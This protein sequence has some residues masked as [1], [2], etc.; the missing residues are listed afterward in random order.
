MKR[1][2]LVPKSGSV[3]AKLFT[4][5]VSRKG[6]KVKKGR[7]KAM[8]AERV[9]TE[10][11]NA[12]ASEPFRLLT[13]LEVLPSDFFRVSTGLRQKKLD[14]F[15]TPVFTPWKQLLTLVSFC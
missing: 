14:S 15:M 12:A 10:E 8:Q 1:C 2:G 7:Q 6:A 13:Q 9:V 4:C 3:R 5:L 11:E